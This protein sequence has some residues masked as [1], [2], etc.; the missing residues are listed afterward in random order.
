MEMNRLKES[1]LRIK[2]ILAHDN[3]F[4]I[5]KDNQLPWMLKSELK[6]FNNSIFLCFIALYKEELLVKHFS[7]LLE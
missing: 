2:V 1:G 7:K 6:N 5:G 3:K 4:G